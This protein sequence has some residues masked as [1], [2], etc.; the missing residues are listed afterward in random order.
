MS[1]D[2][3]WPLS[4]TINKQKSKWSVCKTVRQLYVRERTVYHMVLGRAHV[5]AHTKQPT[6]VV[7]LPYI[8]RSQQEL[9]SSHQ[10]NL[11]RIVYI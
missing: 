11:N 9:R 1:A 2:Q 8:R 7:L 4:Q 5:S 10:Q 6:A 3:H